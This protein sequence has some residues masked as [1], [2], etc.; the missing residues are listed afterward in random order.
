MPTPVEAACGVAPPPRALMLRALMLERERVA[1]HLGDL[2]ALGND[3]AFAF[4]LTQFCALKEQ[5]V[6]LNQQLFGHRFLMDRIVPGGVAVDLDAAGLAAIVEQC[7]RSA[8]NWRS[9]ACST[10]STPACRTASPPP[11][12]STPRWRASLSLSGMAARATGILLDGRIHRQGYT[13]PPPYATL[14]VRP[15]TDERG[16]VAARVAVRFDEVFESLRLLRQMAVGMPAGDIRIAGRPAARRRRPRRGRRLARRS[17]GRRPVRRRRQPGPRPSPRSLVAGLAGAGARGDEGHRPRLPADQQVLQPFLQRSRPVIPLL[18]HIFR[19]GILTEPM[20]EAEG[21]PQREIDRLHD[22][23][24]RILGRALTI[25]EVDAGSCNACE[26]EIH[27]LNNPYYNLEGR[28]I[29]F[30]ASPRHADMLLVT[31]PVTKN[32]ENALRIAHD[33]TPDPKLV[34]AVG[35]CGCN[36]GVFGESYASCGAVGN[37]V[38]VDLRIPGCPPTPLALMQGILAAVRRTK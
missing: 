35:D 10:T 18:R 24:L 13:P 19:T 32:M 22:E 31:G 11:A 26:L 16:D 12:S 14:G 23:I 28:G 30:V 29:K 15:A 6:R 21:G 8:P 34:V 36:G 27:A 37:V 17:A 9:C 25:R 33:C 3:A 5:W 7:T 4:G 2:G 1:N 20:P 38:E